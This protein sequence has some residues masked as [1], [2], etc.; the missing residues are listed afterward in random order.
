MI[1]GLVTIIL[2]VLILSGCAPPTESKPS[3]VPTPTLITPGQAQAMMRDYDVTV[4]DVRTLDE[5]ES[6]HIENAVLLPIDELQDRAF[7][8]IGSLDTVLLIY[9]QSGRRSADAALTLAALGFARVY[10]F[11]G[12]LSWP[13]EVVT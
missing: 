8:V 9:C 4:L 2:S 10:D 1:K 11:G 13:G 3:P 7:S 12:I 5:F 6:G